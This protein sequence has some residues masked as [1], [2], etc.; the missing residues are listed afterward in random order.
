[1]QWCSRDEGCCWDHQLWRLTAVPSLTTSL[2]WRE[3][4][5][6]VQEQAPSQ[7]QAVVNGR[8]IQGNKD[9]TSSFLLE[10]LW[11]AIQLQRPLQD[12][13]RPLGCNPI[14]G[15]FLALPSSAF[16]TSFLEGSLE[17]SPVTLQAALYQETVSRKPKPSQSCISLVCRALHSQKACEERNTSFHQNTFHWKEGKVKT[18][19]VIGREYRVEMR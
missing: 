10:H 14:M 16:L 3:L 12:W 18:E 13:L 9:L 2:C 17:S 6:L 1:M 15:Q 5:D 11:E 4:P 19:T 8:L 7:G